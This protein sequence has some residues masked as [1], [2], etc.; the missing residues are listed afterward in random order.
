MWNIFEYCSQNEG[1]K[2]EVFKMNGENEYKKI[3]RSFFWK[4]IREEII[5]G[6]ILIAMFYIVVL[7][8]K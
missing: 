8:M 1:K 5:S 4:R 3:T 2:I 6:V 7:L